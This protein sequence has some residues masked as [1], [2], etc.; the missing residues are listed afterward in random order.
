MSEADTKTR[1]L[2][3]AEQLFAGNSFHNT[4]MRAITGEANAN[5]AAANYHFG[6]KEALL[7]AVFERRL[8]PLNQLRRERLQ[9]VLESAEQAGAA[10]VVSDL[11]RAFI[12]PTLAFRDRDSGTRAFISLVGRAMVETDST[13]RDCFIHLVEPLFRFL[14]SSLQRALPAM[15]PPV[16]YTRLQFAMGAMAH[17]M[18]AQDR[19]PLPAGLPTAEIE[20]GDLAEPLIDFIRAGLEAP[21]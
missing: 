9:R 1:L 17:T 16:L 14:F 4:S 20:T 8:L 11:V 18:C 15:P 12:E 10:P 7:Q 2:D 6:S 13:V 3:A 19:A 21:C 5:L